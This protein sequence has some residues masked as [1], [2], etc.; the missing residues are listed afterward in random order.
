M[1]ASRTLDH[2]PRALSLFANMLLSG[3]IIFG[4]GPVLI[5]LLREYVVQPGWV[6]SRDFLIGLAIIQT[7]PGPN[8]NFAV[9]V[10]F[11][12]ML[13]TD[14]SPVLG[15]W[16][17][18]VGIF[19]PGLAVGLGFMSIWRVL[20]KQALVISALRGLN[21]TAIGLI[22]TAVYRIWQIGFLSTE[23]PGGE[24]LN[25]EPWWLVVTVTTYTEVA[26]FKIPIPIAIVAGGL[27]GL[28]WFGVTGSR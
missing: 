24:S 3:T 17:G 27:L 28:C 16:L 22:F 20:R 26:W 18:F 1:V 13:G 9:Y 11:L 15:G 6:S 5:P 21:Y 23:H 12:A 25:Q 2:P 14:V 4:G 8:F 10:G 7:M 19:L